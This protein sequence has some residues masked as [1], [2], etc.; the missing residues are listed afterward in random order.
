MA[1]LW[2]G[3]TGQRTKNQGRGNHSLARTGENAPTAGHEVV[4]WL[5][6]SSGKASQDEEP[7]WEW[8]S[9][10]SGLAAAGHENQG[11]MA[12]WGWPWGWVRPLMQ[13]HSWI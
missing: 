13:V 9:D 7:D 4:D 11:K 8:G 3:K 12:A 2:N 10:R 6:W 5:S 1:R